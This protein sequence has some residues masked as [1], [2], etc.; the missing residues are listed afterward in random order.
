MSFEE[1]QKSARL[2]VIGAL[3]DN[4]IREFEKRASK[5][6]P[7]GRGFHHRMLSAARSIRAQPSTCEVIPGLEGRLMKMVR[8]RKQGR[9][10]LQRKARGGDFLTRQAKRG[11]QSNSRRM[12]SWRN[13]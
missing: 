4:E 1:F 3:E 10:G 7:E 2:Y 13:P 11:S 12:N 8:E 5:I 9:P 6:W